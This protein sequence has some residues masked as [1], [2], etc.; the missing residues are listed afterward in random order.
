MAQEIITDRDIQDLV[1]RAARANDALLSGDIGGYLAL[2][3]HADDYTLMA[4]FGGAP[5][6]GFD[7]SSERLAGLA[8]FFKSGKADLELVRSYASGDMVVLAII[9]RQRAAIGGLPEQDWSLRVTLVFRRE[10][11]EWQLVHRH[12]DPL[13]RDV[14]LETAAAIARGARLGERS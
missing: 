13:V 9:E 5:T 10:G 4:P 6:H 3:R 7:L 12:A 1:Q 8:R 14:G 2:I 11:S